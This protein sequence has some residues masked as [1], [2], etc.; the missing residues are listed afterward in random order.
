MNNEEKAPVTLVYR[1]TE[2]FGLMEVNYTPPPQQQ[3]EERGKLA[4][5]VAL[6]DFGYIETDRIAH[7]RIDEP[8]AFEVLKRERALSSA[9]IDESSLQ[10]LRDQL[11][12]GLKLNQVLVLSSG[13]HGLTD[14]AF[15]EDMK[16]VRLARDE[17]WVR[18]G[19]NKKWTTPGLDKKR[20]KMAKASKKRNRK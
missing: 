7:V 10:P 9:V 19:N 2:D 13:T 1:E 18:T 6:D 17:E 12:A 5:F 4:A 16:R 8:S 14:G 20:K 3:Q 11:E 15:Q